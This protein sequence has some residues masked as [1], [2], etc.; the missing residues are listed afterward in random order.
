MAPISS[1]VS[2]CMSNTHQAT[3]PAPEAVRNTPTEASTNAGR[4]PTRKVSARVRMPPSSR[5]TPSARLAIRNASSKSS[6][7]MPPGPSS[8]MIMPTTRKIS[9]TGMPSLLDSGLS[10]ML[11][12]SI[13]APIRVT[14]GSI[15]APAWEYVSMIAG[16][17]AD[18]CSF[19]RG[20]MARL[21]RSINQMIPVRTTPCSATWCMR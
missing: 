13:R 6:K 18:Q 15:P 3:R 14:S 8:P 1:A 19:R 21:I 20:C 7:R 2:Q 4:R 16:S 9:S 10:M 12:T 17:R 11:M 5:I